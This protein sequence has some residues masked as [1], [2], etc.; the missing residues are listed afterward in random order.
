VHCHKRSYSFL[1]GVIVTPPPARPY[2]PATVLY[3]QIHI[4]GLIDQM[5]KLHSALVP[6]LEANP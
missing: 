3:S 4:V 5:G 1:Y 6:A 2:L